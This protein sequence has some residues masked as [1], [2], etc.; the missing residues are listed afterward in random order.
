[1]KYFKATILLLGL[2]FSVNSL[3]HEVDVKKAMDKKFLSCTDNTEASYTFINGLSPLLITN[4]INLN[5]KK[6]S[7]LIGENEY[8]GIKDY[9]FYKTAHSK[10]VDFSVN[11][12]KYGLNIIKFSTVSYGKEDNEYFGYYII[13]KNKLEEITEALNLKTAESLQVTPQGNIKLMCVVVG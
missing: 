5:S 6:S 1:M 12:K 11:F 8:L 9:K 4:K 2:C 13:F 3:A 7:M 10:Q